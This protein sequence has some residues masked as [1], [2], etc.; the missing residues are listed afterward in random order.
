MMTEAAM[1]KDMIDEKFYDCYIKLVELFTRPPRTSANLV[2]ELAAS[3]KKNS[4]NTISIMLPTAPGVVKEVKLEPEEFKAR[5]T[6]ALKE[7]K[8]E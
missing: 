1:C 3:D 6:E 7:L 8:A 2:C 4:N 5:Y